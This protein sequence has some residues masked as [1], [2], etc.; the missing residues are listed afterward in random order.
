MP[1]RPRRGEVPP[2]HA[3]SRRA[4][5]PAGAPRGTRGAARCGAERPRGTAAFRGRLTRVPERRT[6]SCRRGSGKLPEATRSSKPAKNRINKLIHKLANEILTN[7]IP[8]NTLLSH[9]LALSVVPCPWFFSY[10]SLPWERF[11]FSIK[12][13]KPATTTM[14][15]S[16]S[17]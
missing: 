7:I 3:I 1:L 16:R 8:K 13:L 12:M 2:P 15:S 17:S 9:L 11:L 14:A 4:G 6:S 5:P 10:A